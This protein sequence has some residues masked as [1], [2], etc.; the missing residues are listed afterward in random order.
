MAEKIRRKILLV[1]RNL[2]PLVGGMER[3]NWHMVAELA[4]YDDIKVIGPQGCAAVAPE[5]VQKVLEVPLK[6]LWKF[7][8]VARRHTCRLARRWKPDLIVAG[9][10]LTAPIALKA[11]HVCGAKAV[12]YAHGLDVAVRHPIYR[13]F[14]LPT[15][16]KVNRVIVNS[17]PTRELCIGIG[18]KPDRIGIVSP[19]VNLPSSPEFGR[20]A[21]FR[22]RHVLGES[23]ILISVGRLSARKGLRELVEHAL[24][25]IVARHPDVQL[26]IAGDTPKDALHAHAQTPDSILAAARKVGVASSLRFLGKI[27]DDELSALYHAADVHVFPVREIPGDPEGFGMVAVEAAAHGLPTVAFAVGGIVDSVEDAKSGYL[28]APGDYMMLVEK[29]CQV[30]AERGKLRTACEEFAERFS[31]SHFGVHLR[32]ELLTSSGRRCVS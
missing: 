20:S 7:L 21:E 29:V 15:I 22:V 11:A 27:D 6:P 2:P 1:T 9:S 12:V 24:P 26:L 5:G 17:R 16:R 25:K 28:V 31:W 14:W 4:K 18:V 13:A 8:L 10:G 3:L 23:P 32:E 30:I 19:G